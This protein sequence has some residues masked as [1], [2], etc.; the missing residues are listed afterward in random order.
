MGCSA[1]K[2]ESYGELPAISLYDGP[3][4]RTLRAFLRERHWPETLSVAVLSA[5]HGLIGGLTPIGAYDQRMTR[6]RAEELRDPTAT[7]LNWKLA[8]SRI[9]LVVGKDYLRSIAPS[10]ITDDAIRVRPG[11]IGKQLNH[12]AETLRR[13]DAPIRARLLS[14]PRLRAP[15]YFLPDWDDFLDIDFDFQRDRFSFRQRRERREAHSI[16]LMRPYQLCDGVLVS[17]AQHLGTKGLLK[18]VDRTSLASRASIGPEALRAGGGS[19]G[20]RRL[21]RLYLRERA[22]AYNFRG[23]GSGSV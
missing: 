17:L 14:P 7:L 18:R 23:T 16:E 11:P 6:N 19:V 2:V 4:F 13:I 21:W 1:T 3:A 22:C 15:L 10:V 8:H 20:L 5:R 12:I 9:D